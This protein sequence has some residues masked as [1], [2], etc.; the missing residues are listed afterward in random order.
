M[1]FPLYSDVILLT[2]L[3]EEGVYAGD[4]G[5]VVERHDVIGLETGYSV[6]FFDMLGNTVSVV[7][8]PMSYFRLPTRADR[9]SVRVMTS[10]V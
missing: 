5:T 3:P 1:N 2:T 9:P 8:L 7:T 4:I 6:E 10:A